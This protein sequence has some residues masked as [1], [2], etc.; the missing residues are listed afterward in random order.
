[1]NNT[2]IKI[3]NAK[4]EDLNEIMDIYRRARQFMAGSGNPSQWGGG[5]P[6]RSLLEQDISRS[7]LFV[8]ES[9]EILGV[10]AFIIGEDPTYLRIDGGAWINDEPYGTIHRIAS[11]GASRNIVSICIDWCS[12]Y[13]SNLRCD[14]HEDNKIMQHLLEKND[15]KR[16]GIIYL[17]NGSP[18]IAYQRVQGN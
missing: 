9:A 3:R 5:Y 12:Q 17:A 15:F 10:F 2:D 8:C 13:S 6:S 1:M 7:R 4:S 16:C 11:S 14:T 18:R